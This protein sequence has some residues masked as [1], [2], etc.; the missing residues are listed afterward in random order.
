MK[1]AINASIGPD[2]VQYI[3]SQLIAER[4]MGDTIYAN[5]VMLGASYQAGLLPLSAKALKQA[6]VLN[7]ANVDQNL[8]AF[9][10]G[11]LWISDQGKIL[12]KISS[13]KGEDVEQ[14]DK[15]DN[16]LSDRYNRLLEYQNKSLAD[17]YKKKCPRL[18]N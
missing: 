16:I 7:G 6:I 9:D 1:L 3:D 8:K 4:L 18:K 12:Q 10:I 5:I 2:S 14:T 11:R 15:F 13:F 17:K